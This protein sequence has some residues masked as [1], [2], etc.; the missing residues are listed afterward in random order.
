MPAYNTIMQAMRVL[1]EREAAT[2]LLHG[3]DP[4]FVGIIRLDNVQNYLI[5]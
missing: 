5:Q 2:T 4:D 1:S 3:T